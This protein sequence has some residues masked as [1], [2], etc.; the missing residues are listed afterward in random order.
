MT[1]G[2]DLIAAGRRKV[3]AQIGGGG[4]RGGGAGNDGDMYLEES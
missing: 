1:D 2:A 4:E 3:G